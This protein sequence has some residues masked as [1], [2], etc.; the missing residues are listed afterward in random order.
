MTLQGSVHPESPLR[1]VDHLHPGS[2]STSHGLEERER[3]VAMEGR[4]RIRIHSG[5]TYL[6]L[7]GRHITSVQLHCP[8]PITWR[9]TWIFC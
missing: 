4:E 5:S 7:E 9:G 8:E 1:P 2:A 3:K 6:G